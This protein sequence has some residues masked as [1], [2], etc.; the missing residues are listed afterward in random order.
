MACRVPRRAVAARVPHV[1]RAVSCLARC[2]VGRTVCWHVARHAA[3]RRAYALHVRLHAGR[4][5]TARVV[6]HAMSERC[7]AIPPA[8]RDFFFPRPCLGEHADG[9]RRG[10]AS[11]RRYPGDR[12]R[13][14]F[15]FP[16][17]PRFESGPRRSLSARAEK[18]SAGTVHPR[19]GGARRRRGRRRGGGGGAVHV[20]RQHAR[21]A[22]RQAQRARRRAPA[23]IGR[24]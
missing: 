23:R 7:F 18:K 2:V 6:N 24:N 20:A 17:P 4:N 16:S 15:F 21:V 12:A 13:R 1:C 3:W 22:R 14:D 10:H 8:E 9:D 5:R 19:S 11:S